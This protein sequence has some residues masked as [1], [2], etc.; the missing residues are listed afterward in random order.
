MLKL[1]YKRKR[2]EEEDGFTP[3]EDISAVPLLIPNASLGRTKT[4]RPR[5][6]HLFV[7]LS[8]QVLIALLRLLIT[9]VQLVW[10]Q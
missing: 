10:A 5:V 7:K 4:W 9:T 6:S 8:G 2:S 1:D 3:E